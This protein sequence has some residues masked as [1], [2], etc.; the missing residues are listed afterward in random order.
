[1]RTG[2]RLNVELPS[3]LIERLRE[4]CRFRGEFS[5][6]IRTAIQEYL[7]RFEGENKKKQP[8]TKRKKG[9]Q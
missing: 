1:M 5:H 7:D 6:I 9:V 4:V 8:K 3:P 2:K